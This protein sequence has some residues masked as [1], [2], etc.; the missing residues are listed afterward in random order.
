MYGLDNRSAWRSAADQGVVRLTSSE[1]VSVDER[2]QTLA[3]EADA[4][5]ELTTAGRHS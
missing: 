4:S 5:G 1:V 2:R 3:G